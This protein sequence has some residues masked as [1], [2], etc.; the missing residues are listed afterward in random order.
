MS[1]FPSAVPE[2][3]PKLLP[4][5]LEL[6]EASVGQPYSV[7]FSATDGSHPPYFFNVGTGWIPPGLRLDNVTGKLSGV[8]T[9][10][11]RYEIAVGVLDTDYTNADSFS[12]QS[13]GKWTGVFATY[14]LNVTGVSDPDAPY[15]SVKWADVDTVIPYPMSALGASQPKSGEARL[16]TVAGV[17]AVGLTAL[18]NKSFNAGGWMGTPVTKASMAY[19]GIENRHY[20]GLPDAQ[21]QEGLDEWVHTSIFF[22]AGYQASGQLDGTWNTFNSWHTDDYTQKLGGNS[23]ALMVFTD[24]A[25]SEKRGIGLRLVLR[26][27]GGDSAKPTVDSTS[28]S[29]KSGELQLQHWYDIVYHFVWSTDPNKGLAEMWLDGKRMCSVKF[30]TLYHH[31]NGTKSWNNGF[32]YYNYRPMH[33]WD[34]TVYFGDLSIGPTARSV[35]FTP[36]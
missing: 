32:G 30:P 36:S 17:P 16:A 27:R 23:N 24:S 31:A 1:V 26:L 19:V 2:V 4:V 3:K 34:S 28:C 13:M 6:P 10:A 18:A 21:E 15:F 14:V 29:Q 11:G 8:P 5:S 12:Y 35:G 25:D 9:R 22:P 20:S 7:T 33:D